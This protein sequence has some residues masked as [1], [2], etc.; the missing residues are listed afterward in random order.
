CAL[1]R[2]GFLASAEEEVDDAAYC[3]GIEA[4]ALASAI[5]IARELRIGED[6]ARSI[7]EQAP[8]RVQIRCQCHLAPLSERQAASRTAPV[9]TMLLTGL[10]TTRSHMSFPCLWFAMPMRRN[11]FQRSFSSRP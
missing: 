11:F 10:M 8:S 1:V 5:H 4:D 2:I 3:A 7:V 9:G 6:P